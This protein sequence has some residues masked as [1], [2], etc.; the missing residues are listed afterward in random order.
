[1][2]RPLT[3]SWESPP[4]VNGAVLWLSSTWPGGSE[5]TDIAGWGLALSGPFKAVRYERGCT[6]TSV[7]SSSMT[8]RTG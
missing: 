7:Q 3:V 2:A 8:W 1:M 6:W 5:F 4:L